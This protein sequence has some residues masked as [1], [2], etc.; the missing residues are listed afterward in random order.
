MPRAPVRVSP[1]AVTKFTQSVKSS[2]VQLRS[3]KTITGNSAALVNRNKNRMAA[4]SPVKT[5]PPKTTNV[6]FPA[7]TKS[8]KVPQNAAKK[9]SKEVKQTKKLLKK[10]KNHSQKEN[11]PTTKGRLK[12]AQLPTQ[13]KIR[14]VPRKGYKPENQL[15]RG[16]GGSYI[17]RFDNKWTKGSSRT[18]GQEFEWDVQLSKKGKSKIGWATRDR[19]HANVSLDGK[20]THK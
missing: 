18:K 2:T 5:T 11:K 4:L 10:V 16:N 7:Q 19:S 9:F 20:I 6:K 12:D 15:P 13:G 3:G 14:F 17:D 8:V 1:P